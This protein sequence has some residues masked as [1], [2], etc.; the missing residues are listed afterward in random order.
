MCYKDEVQKKNADKLQRKFEEDNIPVFIRDYFYNL[1]SE[2]GKLNYF[3]IIISML[4]WMIEHKR[5]VCQ[6]IS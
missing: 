3:S 5:I 6:S 2:A 4:N 1:N